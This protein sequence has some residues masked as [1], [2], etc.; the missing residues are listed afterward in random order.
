MG[1]RP[2]LAPPWSWVNRRN[3]RT[4]QVTVCSGAIFHDDEED[5][6]LAFKDAVIKRSTRR[7]DIDKLGT[8][9]TDENKDASVP[10]A[11][12]PDLQPG[13]ATPPVKRVLGGQ[14]TDLIAGLPAEAGS[15]V[16]AVLMEV[17]AADADTHVL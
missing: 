6:D 5:G 16:D 9:N 10:A 11:K 14:G 17:S 2:S 15:E 13:S 8:R 3:S 4:P 7:H 12:L 1:S